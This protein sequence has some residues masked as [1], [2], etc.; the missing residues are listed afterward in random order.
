MG[1]NGEADAADERPID[2]EVVRWC[3][4]GDQQAQ[5]GDYDGAIAHYAQALGLLAAPVEAWEAATYIF[6]AIGNTYFLKGEYTHAYRAL[7]HAL[8]C[9][10]A[11]MDALIHLRIGQVFLRWDNQDLAANELAQAYMAGGAAIFEGEDARYLALVQSV[12]RA[13]VDG[14]W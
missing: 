7:Q 2:A 10:R 8:L 12:L 3:E 11:S 9:P 4:S 1:G 14:V 5:A 13:P 6:A